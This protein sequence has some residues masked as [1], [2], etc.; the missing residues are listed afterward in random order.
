MGNA[1]RAKGIKEARR[2]TA[3]KNVLRGLAKKRPST[4]NSH[5]TNKK[6]KQDDPTSKRHK[7]DEPTNKK[8]KQNEATITDEDIALMEAEYRAAFSDDG[9]DPQN[10]TT[11]DAPTPETTRNET[12][13][14]MTPETT[15][16]TRRKDTTPERQDKTTDDVQQSPADVPFD[17]ALAL[18]RTMQKGKAP[19]TA[20]DDI[21]HPDEV[22]ARYQDPNPVTEAVRLALIEALKQDYPTWT[23]QQRDEFRQIAP[24][25]SIIVH[26]STNTISSHR[27]HKNN[28]NNPNWV[29]CWMLRVMFGPQAVA[30]QSYFK[31]IARQYPALREPG[32]SAV[33]P[34]NAKQ[35]IDGKMPW[36]PPRPHT[37]IIT[38]EY[39]PTKIIKPLI[40][41]SSTTNTPT[42]T[43]STP[44]QRTW[45]GQKVSQDS[46]AGTSRGLKQTTA[47]T[48]NNRFS[49]VT[50]PGNWVQLPVTDDDDSSADSTEGDNTRAIHILEGDV[51]RL[52]AKVEDLTTKNTALQQ[53]LDAC[54]TH[55]DKLRD[56]INR[57][58]EKC[59]LLAETLCTLQTFVAKK[60]QR[61]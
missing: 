44:A 36:T 10:E 55:I 25:Q 56:T 52:Q 32:P 28:M 26:P 13:D 47:P 7:P 5:Q 43:S 27:M 30:R 46:A 9:D 53:Q 24:R 6:H 61:K 39:T 17:S 18:I 60:M 23:E 54:E 20:I 38:Q 48:L 3:I 21:P 41:S 34:P 59:N 45:N 11:E 50:L 31:D 14:P 29:A 51:D 37:E 12:Q 58:D 40:P 19:A 35:I 22:F 49:D 4:S 42:K 2:T 33:V 57:T 8:H 16:D 15:D 1:K